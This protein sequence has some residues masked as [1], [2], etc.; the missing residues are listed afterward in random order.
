[1]GA[2]VIDR[3]NGYL[4]PVFENVRRRIRSPVVVPVG[5]ARFTARNHEA[6]TDHVIA[7]TEGI[8]HRCAELQVRN[9]L[10]AQPGF[11]DVNPRN[12]QQIGDIFGQTTTIAKYS[13][14]LNP[15]WR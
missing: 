11:Y 14:R 15:H 6:T 5:S 12:E 1:M 3:F 2:H 7:V 13:E 9:D 8:R 10:V 4:D